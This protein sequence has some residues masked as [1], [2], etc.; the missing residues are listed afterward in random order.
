MADQERTE[1]ATPK[2]REDAKKEGNIARS[3]EIPTSIILICCLGVFYF[4][5]SYMFRRLPSIMSS[6]LQNMSNIQLNP[7]SIKYIIH[8][9]V[10]Q[11]GVILFPLMITVI[12]AAVL[13]NVI[14]VGFNINGKILTP[15]FTKLNPLKGV[16]RI[17]SIKSL[18]ELI[19]SIIKISVIGGVGFLVI[20]SELGILP[21]I[22]QM[23]VS[24][25][26]AIITNASFKI[27]FYSCLVFILLAI[28]D[29]GFQ[30]WQFEKKIRMTKQEV[31]DEYKQRE[32]DPLVKA[33]IKNIQKELSKKRMMES[34]PQADVIITNPTELAIAIKYDSEKM[35]APK[36]IAKGAGYIAKRIREIAEKNKI[37]II[38][39]K[40]LAQILYKKID[41]GSAIP[42]ELY[43]AVAEILAYVYGIGKMK[44]YRI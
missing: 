10:I 3:Q 13:S 39:N 20:K 22:M 24:S 34:I 21:S 1:K 32:G 18:A 38:E 5:G 40:P 7:V 17:F 35:S 31:K 41:I 27:A 6:W 37:P 28:L 30:R 12:F 4:G 19:K 9:V 26:F 8:D 23:S 44:S 15:K 36:V 16:K 14:Q 42:I 33:R 25:Q 29:Y 43:H 11:M 2:K